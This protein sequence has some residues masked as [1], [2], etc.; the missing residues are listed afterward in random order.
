MKIET[1]EIKLGAD[2][3]TVCGYLVNGNK[4]VP[5]Q[6][7]NNEYMLIKEWI[8]NGGVCEE[9]NDIETKE[10]ERVFLINQKA[11]SI[12]FSK[13]PLEKQSSAQLGIYGDEYLVDMKV[14]IADIIK[15]S[16][17]LVADASKTDEDFIVSNIGGN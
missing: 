15:Q 10:K 9:Y 2:N 14:F 13:Y 4:Y 6:E 7:N 16:N 1:V 3:K 5:L 17:E 11:S 12:I 8:D